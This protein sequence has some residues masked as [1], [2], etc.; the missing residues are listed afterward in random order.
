MRQIP[1]ESRMKSLIVL[2]LA[3]LLSLGSPQTASA[4]APATTSSYS[5]I[6]GL[7]GGPGDQG[8][9]SIT[10]SPTGQYTLRGKIA[11]IGFTNKGELSETG[12]V[13]D[14]FMV[15]LLGGLIKIPVHLE[16]TV[17]PDQKLI[18]GNATF[19]FKGEVASLNFTLLRSAKY[20]K[21]SPAPQTGRHVIVFQPSEAEDAG[22]VPG[23][24]V[25][26]VNVSAT[27]AVTVSGVLADGAKISCG[28]NVSED[29]IF[30]ILNVLY[31]RNG[32]L[33][34][35]A[36]FGEESGTTIAWA[37]FTNKGAPI[38][39]G[40]LFIDLFPYTPPAAGSPVLNFGT[41][42]NVAPFGLYGGG[43]PD[44]TPIP[45]A[46]SDK[47][48]ATVS[49]ENESKLQL[50]INRKTGWVSG[51]I[52]VEIEG[53]TQRRAIKLVVLQEFNI[54]EGFFI[55]PLPHANVEFGLP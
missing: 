27:G 20:T 48:K 5:G 6:I 35:F 13:T 22:P 42:G 54:A 37:R 30:P 49:G 53:K 55:S 4:G 14:D 10:T 29:G 23:R 26:T 45:V 3:L 8:K 36:Q 24:G 32:F 11:G 47:N 17:S 52:K 18:E 39:A 44:F 34:G 2:G 41:E 21:D 7:G 12:T 51:S 19:Q 31:G 16:F 25:A 50:E 15:K 1:T 28:G 46:V 43:L 33:A 40:E 9:I 38:F